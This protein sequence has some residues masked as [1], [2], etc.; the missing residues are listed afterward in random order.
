[1]M[2]TK[3]I[4]AIAALGLIGAV[5]GYQAGRDRGAPPT[6]RDA[7]SEE[8][9]GANSAPL[10]EGELPGEVSPAVRAAIGSGVASLAVGDV[11]GAFGALLEI[12]SAAE[13]EQALFELSSLRSFPQCAGISQFGTELL[14]LL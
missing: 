4:F 5:A 7:A 2:V 6:G 14:C 9:S 3:P 12:G 13:R 8:D 1:M 10:L 11:R